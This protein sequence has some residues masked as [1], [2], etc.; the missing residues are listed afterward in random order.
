MA[1]NDTSGTSTV[2]PLQA[3]N[4]NTLVPHDHITLE[5]ALKEW[6]NVKEDEDT[7]AAEEEIK[8]YVASKGEKAV[9]QTLTWDKEAY[10]EIL[11][12][13]EGAS[14]NDIIREHRKKLLLC[15]PD[16]VR[17][18]FKGA[19]EAFLSKSLCL[20]QEHQ[21]TRMRSDQQCFQYPVGC[22]KAQDV[23]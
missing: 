4:K 7:K 23:R 21:L 14:H 12:V 19:N 15:H 2:L 11:G 6:D 3:A 13:V 9:T 20:I 18:D 1:S 22:R 10:Y 8:D 17:Q 16:R 5:Q